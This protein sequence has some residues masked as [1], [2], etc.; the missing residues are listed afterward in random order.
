MRHRGAPSF[1]FNMLCRNVVLLALISA[2]Q[3]P[4][5]T[6][7]L[8]DVPAG[9]LKVCRGAGGRRGC[10]QYYACG[11]CYVKLLKSALKNEC[12]L[13]REPLDVPR[14]HLFDRFRIWT[15]AAFS[16]AFEGISEA[17]QGILIVI[18]III[19]IWCVPLLPDVDLD[20]HDLPHADLW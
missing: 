16:A 20:E 4:V 11:R 17:F 18:V 10:N 19:F 13:C 14:H 7:C 15:S 5:C 12:P 9:D 2:A 8:H 3:A 6:L 1:C